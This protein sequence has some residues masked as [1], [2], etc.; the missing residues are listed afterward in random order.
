[1]L[2]A[3]GAAGTVGELASRTAVLLEV[4]IDFAY[5]DAELL[6]RGR[7]QESF[8]NADSP[9]SSAL[10]VRFSNE[11]GVRA[12]WGEFLDPDATECGLALVGEP[13]SKP[14]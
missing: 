7:A 12:N 11:V 9:G 4:G 8:H 13:L 2:V 1:M 6:V 10:R 5:E 14:E 3:D